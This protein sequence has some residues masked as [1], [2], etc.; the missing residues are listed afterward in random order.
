[1]GQGNTICNSK[2][3]SQVRDHT[4]NMMLP[5]SKMKTSFTAFT[6]SI[7]RSLPLFEKF[8]QWHITHRKYAKVPVQRH[9]PFIGM[10]RHCC[11]YRN[12]FLSNTTKP[13]GNSSLPQQDQHFFFN[14][15]GPQ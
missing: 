12:S 5:V 2:L 4:T 9:D 14:Q 13:F 15:P 10:Q 1:M 8:M 6:V 3:R 7:L 11:T